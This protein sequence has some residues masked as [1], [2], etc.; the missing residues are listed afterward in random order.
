M[1]YTLK[2]RG[3]RKRRSYAVSACWMRKTQFKDYEDSSRYKRNKVRISE[4]DQVP[5]IIWMISDK[6]DTRSGK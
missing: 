3:I 2:S 5:V 1:T 4:M 6:I